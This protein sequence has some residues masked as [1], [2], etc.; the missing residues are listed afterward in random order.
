MFFFNKKTNVE[1]ISKKELLKKETL[2]K[3]SKK[4]NCDDF[5]CVVNEFFKEYFS[6]HHEFTLLELKH[7]L[8][9][10]RLDKSLHDEI[11]EFI[12]HLNEEKYNQNA[13]IKVDESRFKKII[14]QLES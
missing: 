5:Y 1:D 3:L 4:M 6:L 14:E 9:H 7:E 12:E 13:K 2:A 8:L 10:K 11:D